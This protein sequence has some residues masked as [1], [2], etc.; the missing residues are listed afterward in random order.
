MAKAGSDAGIVATIVPPAMNSWRCGVVARQ[1]PFISQA[2]CPGAGCALDC[3]MP[4][5][6]MPGC[7]KES[8]PKSVQGSESGGCARTQTRDRWWR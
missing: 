2:I 4:T 1:G 7:G 3:R 6:R 5:P 8:Q